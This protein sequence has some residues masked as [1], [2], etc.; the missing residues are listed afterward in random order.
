MTHA[1]SMRVCLNCC[2]KRTLSCTFQI[3]HS[4]SLAWQKF[5]ITQNSLIRVLC[6]SVGQAQVG[7]Q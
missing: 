5:S 2:L 4:S 6:A 3:G 7:L 1:I